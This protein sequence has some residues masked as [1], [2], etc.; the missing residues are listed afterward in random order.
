[1]K[2]EMHTYLVN[3]IRNRLYPVICLSLLKI[4]YNEPKDEFQTY[5]LEHGAL[6]SI[7]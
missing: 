2:I 5:D 7:F 3:R 1:M 6:L 4:S